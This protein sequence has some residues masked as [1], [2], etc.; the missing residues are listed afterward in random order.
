[1]LVIFKQISFTITT[2]MNPVL[3]ITNQAAASL[4]LSDLF[5]NLFYFRCENNND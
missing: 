1:M 4:A 2:M 5:S 3:L